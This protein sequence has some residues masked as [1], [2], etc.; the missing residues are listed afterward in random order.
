MQKAYSAKMD[1][2][3]KRCEGGDGPRRPTRKKRNGNQKHP[4][5]LVKEKPFKQKEQGGRQWG[6]PQ[7]CST[8]YTELED[9]EGK[10]VSGWT[11]QPESGNT[12]KEGRTRFKELERKSSAAMA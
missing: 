11:E 4:V 9:K 10:K 6:K 12:K 5:P 8:E 7:P 1:Q 2:P 3:Q